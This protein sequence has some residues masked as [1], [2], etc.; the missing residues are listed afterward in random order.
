MTLKRPSDLDQYTTGSAALNQN[1]VV[2]MTV[3]GTELSKL[4]DFT[5]HETNIVIELY[6]KLFRC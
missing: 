6:S 4:N 1:N 3:P 2:A 5:L